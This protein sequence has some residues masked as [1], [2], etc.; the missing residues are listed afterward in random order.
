MDLMKMIDSSQLP[1][2]HIWVTLSDFFLHISPLKGHKGQLLRKM[3][4]LRI[5][6]DKMIQD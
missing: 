4:E 1:V 5:K 6:L 2:T 3:P